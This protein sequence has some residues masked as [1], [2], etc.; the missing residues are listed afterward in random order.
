MGK[1]YEEL[2]AFRHSENPSVTLSERGCPKRDLGLC[3]KVHCGP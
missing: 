3:E 2:L 1:I